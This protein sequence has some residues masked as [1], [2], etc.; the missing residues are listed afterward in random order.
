MRK[1][2]KSQQ[3]TQRRKIKNKRRKTQLRKKISYKRM[4]GG[5]IS[6][7][8]KM[9]LDQI[10]K[11]INDV[12]GSSNRLN[13]Y[14]TKSLDSLFGYAGL[15]ADFLRGKINPRYLS[16][17]E[18]VIV[19]TDSTD[20]SDQEKAPTDVKEPLISKEKSTEI[21]TP[22]DFETILKEVTEGRLKRT[23]LSL[24]SIR[25]GKLNRLLASLR[26]LNEFILKDLLSGLIAVIEQPEDKVINSVPPPPKEVNTLPTTISEDMPTEPI[27]ISHDKQHP[28]ENFGGAISDY[29]PTHPFIK[30]YLDKAHDDIKMQRLSDQEHH[31]PPPSPPLTAVDKIIKLYTS[32]YEAKNNPRQDSLKSLPSPSTPPSFLQ[33]MFSR[34][35]K[36]DEIA[37]IKLLSNL[38]IN[39][40]KPEAKIKLCEV[41]KTDADKFK[42]SRNVTP[43]MIQFMGQYNNLK[44]IHEMYTRQA[45]FTWDSNRSALVYRF[46]KRDSNILEKIIHGLKQEGMD[47]KPDFFDHKRFNKD[48]F[49]VEPILIAAMFRLHIGFI[50]ESDHF[51]KEG[52]KLLLLTMLALCIEYLKRKPSETVVY[53]FKDF[54]CTSEMM[55]ELLDISSKIKIHERFYDEKDVKETI[56]RIN[57]LEDETKLEASNDPKDKIERIT[58]EI[59]TLKSLGSR[60]ID[61]FGGDIGVDQDQWIASILK[62]KPKEEDI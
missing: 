62:L 26:S 45:T 6:L 7:K 24:K 35:K 10:Q 55:K 47:I 33:S 52:T 16:I 14:Y 12:I 30:S 57:L 28:L 37:I 44:D 48:G 54:D 32:R 1:I 59:H 41:Q 15:G 51:D 39:N 60:T 34:K 58:K 38:L 56:R 17:E 22:A 23:L 40:L 2:R 5:A 8:E 11:A 31:L 3:T 25:I 36:D 9:V 4:R 42:G 61:E 13:T 21:L 53:D 49:I 20:S 46:D 19:S 29:D 27:V 50:S 43:N 18:P